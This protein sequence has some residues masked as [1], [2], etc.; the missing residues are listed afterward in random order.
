MAR[1]HVGGQGRLQVAA[2]GVL[3]RNFAGLGHQVG[4]QPVVADDRRR[5][6]DL[7]M[8][9]QARFDRLQLGTHPVF[10]RLVHIPHDLF[11]ADVLC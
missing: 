11:P 5:G 1:H 8:F 7:R 9:G 2:Q 10:A 3:V 4:D 6:S